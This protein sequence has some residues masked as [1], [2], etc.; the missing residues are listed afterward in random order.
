MIRNVVN[1]VS[2][3]VV[4]EYTALCARNIS[5]TSIN[6]SPRSGCFVEKKG[7]NICSAAS[8]DIPGPLSVISIE[9]GM[10]FMVILPFDAPMLSMEFFTILT[11]ARSKS[12]GSI[13][14]TMPVAVV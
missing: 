10:H 3:S 4:S 2:E 12:I 9:S 6:P 14:V 11:I 7:V 5:V 8:A 1:R 13:E